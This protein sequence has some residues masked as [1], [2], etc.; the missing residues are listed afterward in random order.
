MF[1]EINLHAFYIFAGCC[2]FP[3]RL[4][5]FSQTACQPSVLGLQPPAV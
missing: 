1:R 5:Q 4:G 3:V 2:Q